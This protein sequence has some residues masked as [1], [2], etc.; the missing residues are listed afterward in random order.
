MTLPPTAPARIRPAMLLAGLTIVAL[1]VALLTPEAPDNSGGQLSTYSAAP[2]GARIAFELSQRLGWTAHRR[3]TQLDSVVDSTTVHAVIGPSSDLGAKE[4]HR[5]LTDVR[6]GGGLLVAVDGGAAIIDS[7]GMGIGQEGRWFTANIDPGCR[8]SPMQGA[9]VLPPRVRH[10]V[11]RRPA[12]GATS[13]LATTDE[14]FGPALRIAIG[15]HVGLGRV[16]VVGSTDLFRNS[17]VRLCPW[18]ADVVV[19]R[20]LEFVRP[21]APSHPT[22]LF[23]E[24]HHGLGMHPGSMRAV[25]RYLAATSSGRFL[26]QALVAGLVLLF[27][28]APRPIIPRDPVRIARRSPLEHADA[29]GHAYADVRATRTA[30]TQLVWGLRRRAGRLVGVASG[31]DDDSFLDGVARRHP[32]LRGATAT[33]RRALR[34]S[35]EPREFLAVGDALRDIE[36]HLTS[37]QLT[38]S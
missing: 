17:A 36:R 3:I 24:Y 14:R 33:V 5:L 19:V 7:L 28:T 16:A 18:G 4:I 1:A 23:D 13:V 25:T 29:L 37:S 31:A 26:F 8:G 9:F 20:A 30:T 35:L 38:A 15:T 12:R 22:L 11:W 32:D 2:G 21:P 27:A 6:A 34:E 10:L